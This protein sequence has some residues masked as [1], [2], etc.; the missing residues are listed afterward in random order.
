MYIAIRKQ[1]YDPKNDEKSKTFKNTMN[2]IHQNQSFFDSFKIISQLPKL[3]ASHMDVKSQ[4]THW[5]WWSK[6][7]N[8]VWIHNSYYEPWIEALK[9]Q[10]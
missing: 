6:P 9:L 2:R 3:S 4:P 7:V 8:L 5:P 1:W 10:A